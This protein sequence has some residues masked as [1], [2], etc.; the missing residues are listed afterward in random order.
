MFF[1]SG[2]RGASRR[3][4]ACS[5]GMNE[6]SVQS[7][8]AHHSRAGYVFPQR[9]SPMNFDQVLEQIICFFLYAVADGNS[10]T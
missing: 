8:Q 5:G 9:T 10:P 3:S 7:S 4:R 1:V 6:K 2:M